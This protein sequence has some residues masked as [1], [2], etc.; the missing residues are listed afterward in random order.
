[1]LKHLLNK[2]IIY[3]LLGKIYN[4]IHP[5]NILYNEKLQSNNSSI[6]DVKNKIVECK[7]RRNE[8][9]N[10]IIAIEYKRKEYFKLFES[11]L[12]ELKLHSDNCYNILNNF[13]EHIKIAICYNLCLNED[14]K[15]IEEIHSINNILSKFYNDEY[16]DNTSIKTIVSFIEKLQCLLD[17]FEKFNL[18]IWETTYVFH[19]ESNYTKIKNNFGIYFSCW[20]D[21]NDCILTKENYPF[22]TDN[23]CI[24]LH[25]SIHLFNIYFLDQFGFLLYLY[26]KLKFY[27]ENAKSWHNC[28]DK[29]M[30]KI[31]NK[32]NKL[33]NVLQSYSSK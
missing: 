3:N 16:N 9:V 7:I 24:E 21:I 4:S 25:N 31:Q 5:N 1:M 10:E 20:K 15:D 33:R 29:E 2:V 14:T 23:M 28:N 19:F 13:A 32:L 22:L 30:L 27:T 11:N 12:Y 26:S 8:L 17:F 18:V 6:L